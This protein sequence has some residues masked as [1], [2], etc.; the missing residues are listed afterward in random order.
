MILRAWLLVIALLPFAA[1]VEAGFL[2]NMRNIFVK[3]QHPVPAID[4]L[5]VNDKPSAMIEVSGKYQLYNPHTKS[6]ISKRYIG[7]KK[8][9]QTDSSGLKWGEGFPGIFQLTI[10]PEDPSVGVSIDGV[11]Y[12]GNVTVYD[13]GGS[14]SIVNRV[15]IEEFLK[16]TLPRMYSEPMPEEAM[17]AIAIVARTNTYYFSCNPKSKFWSIDAAQV[18]YEGVESQNPS[19]PMDQAVSSTRHMILSQTGAYEGKITPFP[20][21]WKE[22]HGAHSGS[23]SRIMLYE[24]EDIARTGGHAA[25][26]LSKAFPG[27]HIELIY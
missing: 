9:M 27:S 20:A 25:Q 15:P 19:S 13:I 14:I 10:I 17:A 21:Q 5:V 6:L 2:S 24:A 7:K 26:I 4:V 3:H 11:A 12:K 8:L 18:G 23:S 22:G 16:S 1:S